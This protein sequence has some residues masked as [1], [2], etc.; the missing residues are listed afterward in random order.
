MEYHHRIGKTGF[1]DI[2]VNLDS[3][4][5]Q[6]IRAGMESIGF[7]FN[8]IVKCFK[9]VGLIIPSLLTASGGVARPVLLQFISDLTN[10][11]IDFSAI[12]DRT[13]IGVYKVL[14]QETFK[15]KRP[16]FPQEIFNPQK[17]QNM[18]DKKT[19]M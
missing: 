13:A 7:L 8:D 1:E 2:Y 12:K 17:I 19:Q 10:L 15:P 18:Q 6:I 4:P 9:D 16:S 11:S 3:N 14:R 5:N